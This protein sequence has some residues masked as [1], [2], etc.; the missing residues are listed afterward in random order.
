MAPSVWPAKVP[1]GSSARIGCHSCCPLGD[2]V[3]QRAPFSAYLNAFPSEEVHELSAR[4]GFRRKAAGLSDPKGES[5]NE[6]SAILHCR[7]VFIGLAL[8]EALIHAGI[9]GEP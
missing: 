6:L 8:H 3:S 2:E 1:V 9:F 7:G 5:P 4:N